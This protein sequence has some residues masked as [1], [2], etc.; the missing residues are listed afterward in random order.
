MLKSG[1][2]NN[3]PNGNY[4]ETFKIS[5]IPFL[6][7]ILFCDIR[8]TEKEGFKYGYQELKL[9]WYENQDNGRMSLPCPKLQ[10]ERLFLICIPF[11]S[12]NL[13]LFFSHQILHNE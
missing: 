5:M 11:F 4:Q 10:Q 2:N 13:S 9:C 8:Q 1:V 7:L 3:Y 6:I 12:W